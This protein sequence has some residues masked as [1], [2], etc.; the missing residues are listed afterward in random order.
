[1]PDSL[2]LRVAAEVRAEM[3]RQHMTQTRLAEVMGISQPQVGQRLK[4]QIAFDTD[5]L[6]RIADALGVPVVPLFAARP[7]PA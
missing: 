5:E 1:M 4:G 3:A 7:V 6:E 2:T